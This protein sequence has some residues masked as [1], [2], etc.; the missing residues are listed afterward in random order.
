MLFL[1]HWVYW[2]VTYRPLHWFLKSLWKFLQG[3][4]SDSVRLV[5][6]LSP[7]SF[8]ALTSWSGKYS[9][10][11]C[12]DSQWDAETVHINTTGPIV[13]CNT[14][15]GERSDRVHTGLACNRMERD[16]RRRPTPAQLCMLTTTV[17]GKR[18]WK[19]PLANSIDPSQSLCA[20]ECVNACV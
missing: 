13:Q 7:S 10:K 4:R 6:I 20:R 8:S 14:S 19:Q 12:M 18:T 2:I 15:P 1:Q 5:Y 11:H 3:R 16:V 9:E 17:A